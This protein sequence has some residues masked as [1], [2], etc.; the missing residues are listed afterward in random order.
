MLEEKQY[1]LNAGTLVNVPLGVVHGFTFEPQTKG[2][3]VT[4]A[5]EL[6]EQGLLES[7]GLR[8]LLRVPETLH[9]DDEIQ[10]VVSA[11]FAKHAPGLLPARM[12]CGRC[13]GC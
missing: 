13:Q 4:L 2:W 5:A 12:Y 10:G 3:M 6:L 11:V 7:E 1:R 8:P 9:Y